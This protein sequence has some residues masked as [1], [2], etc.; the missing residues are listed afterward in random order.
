MMPSFKYLFIRIH[1]YTSPFPTDNTIG[2][3][4]PLVRVFGVAVVVPTTNPRPKLA[5]RCYVADV[6]W[7]QDSEYFVFSF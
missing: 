4:Q 6:C 5:A 2:S 7:N 3:L 1:A